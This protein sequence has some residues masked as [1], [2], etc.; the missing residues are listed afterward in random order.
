MRFTIP[1]DIYFGRGAIESLKE[2]KGTRAVIV[3]GGSSMQNSGFMDKGK[4][5]LG[6]GGFETFLLE[7][8]EPDPDIKTVM[9]GAAFMLKHEPDV[10]VVIG[11]G[12]AIDAAKA[13]WIFY[14][15][16][17]MTF[18]AFKSPFTLPALRKKAI[19]AAIPS[20]SGTASEVTAFSVITD[21]EPKIKY[22]LADYQLTPDMA[23]IDPDLADTMPKE[24]VAHTGMDALTHAIEAYTATA[25]SEF[26]DPLA[27]H[28]I[29][30]I[31][32]NL[33]MSYEGK[34]EAAEKMH[35][36]Q[37]MAG[38]AFSNALLGIAH[39]LAHKTGAALGIPHG[40]ANAI[41]LPYVIRFNANKEAA[42][43]KQNGIYSGRSKYAEIATH[44]GVLEE[45]QAVL[46]RKL[47]ERIESMN[48]ALHIPASLREA[49]IDKME[50]QSLADSIAENAATDPCTAS[51]PRHADKED[52]RKLLRCI[53]EG[54]VVDF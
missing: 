17:E 2:L 50:F 36:A 27:L 13:M 26:S 52:L 23:I 29:K 31:F 45:D 33:V 16:P 11:G 25:S 21:Y 3:T 34:K 15:H 37:C 7:G 40:L 10:I 5:I 1:R 22:P 43:Y 39:S 14:E 12:S 53:Y 32:G 28:S 41:Y 9:K 47:I 24:L 30:R 42:T 35:Y 44:I 48:R 46:T 38:M 4:K 19:F 20:T 18:E 8:I 51:N 49:G 54:S 6:E